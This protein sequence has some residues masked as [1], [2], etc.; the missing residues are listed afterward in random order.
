MPMQY[1]TEKEMAGD[2]LSSLK[3][4]ATGY[5]HS[6][7]ESADPQLRNTFKDYLNQSFSAQERIF[8]Y[9]QQNGMYKVPRIMDENNI[10][11]GPGAG[12]G[13]NPNQIPIR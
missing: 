1:I 10:N 3:L 2:L 5:A 7:M 8:N 12:P 4:S 11:V 6:V 9:M 13:T